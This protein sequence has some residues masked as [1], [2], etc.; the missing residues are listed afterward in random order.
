M[1]DKDPPP[2]NPISDEEF[3]K[4]DARLTE[5]LDDLEKEALEKK[6]KPPG[7]GAMF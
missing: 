3:A 2:A 1:T 5:K 7:V 6:P 4:R